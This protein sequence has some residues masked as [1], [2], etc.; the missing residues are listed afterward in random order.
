MEFIGLDFESRQVEASSRTDY[1]DGAE[2]AHSRL[3]KPISDA[4]VGRWTNEMSAEEVM[5]FRQHAGNVL[6]KFDY[7]EGAEVETE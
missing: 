6:E 1:D 3:Q 2:G 4:S 5:D 7:K